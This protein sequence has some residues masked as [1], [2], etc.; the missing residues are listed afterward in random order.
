MKT[1]VTM[2]ITHFWQ[3]LIILVYQS[4]VSEFWQ[5]IALK[6]FPHWSSAIVSHLLYAKMKVAYWEEDIC[7][8]FFLCVGFFILSHIT[9]FQEHKVD[10]GMVLA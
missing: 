7:S 2:E 10:L 9:F 8:E 5:P 3:P 4:L 6:Y 1:S